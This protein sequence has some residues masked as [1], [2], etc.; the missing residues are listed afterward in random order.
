VD[1]LVWRS[2]EVSEDQEGTCLD[3]KVAFWEM[4]TASFGLGFGGMIHMDEDHP[5]VGWEHVEVGLSWRHA[6]RS[7]SAV[8][9]VVALE[10]D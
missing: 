9:V 10:E 2:E 5:A 8:A 1:V 7:R 4:V 6:L 3:W